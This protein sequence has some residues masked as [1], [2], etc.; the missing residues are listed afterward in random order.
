MNNSLRWITYGFG[1]VSVAGIALAAACWGDSEVRENGE[2]IIFVAAMGLVWLTAAHLI[3]PWF[4]ISFRDD[5]DERKNPAATAALCGA[6]LGI[7]L[8]Y[9]GSSTGDGPTFAENFFSAALG[10]FALFVLWGL[11]EAVGNVST[12]IAEDRDFASG[13]RLGMFLLSVGLIFGRALAGN[14]HSVENTID[15]FIYDGW[16]TVFIWILA[17]AVEKICRPTR[18]RPFPRWRIFGLLPGSLYFALAII[19]V[20]HLGRWEGIP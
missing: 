9:A 2:E 10:T 1:A 13:L 14:W 6:L 12:S 8:I 4:G 19:W 20:W 17:A 5:V 11:L 16:P 7:G 15:D 3:F 18:T